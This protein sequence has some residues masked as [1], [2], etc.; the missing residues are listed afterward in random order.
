LDTT[1][2]GVLEVFHRL[3]HLES[4]SFA[5]VKDRGIDFIGYSR[6]KFVA[7]QIKTS[8]QYFD[9]YTPRGAEYC[10]WWEVSRALH[11]EIL[12]ENVFY[13]F[14]GVHFD[15]RGRNAIGYDFFIINSLELDRMFSDKKFRYDTKNSKWRIEIYLDR[16]TSRFLSAFD[17]S[18][19][20]TAFHN[21]WWKI[22]E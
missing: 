14:V 1:H 6:R 17:S 9:R 8:K 20:L 18:C 5:P 11:R 7:F 10:Y 3:S 12:S 4:C 13:I 21:A 2:L 19:D 16:N 15:L 22:I